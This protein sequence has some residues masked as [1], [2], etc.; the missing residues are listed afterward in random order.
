MRRQGFETVIA[1]KPCLL[2]TVFGGG[3]FAPTL[4]RMR[5]RGGSQRRVP[6]KRTGCG[7][8]SALVTEAG[9]DPSPVSIVGFS[10]GASMAL[11]LALSHPDLS[12]GYIAFAGGLP[13]E[14]R[15]E[16]WRTVDGAPV[17]L[18]YGTRDTRF[19]AEELDATIDTLSDAREQI[20][21]GWDA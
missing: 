14:V 7:A 15:A 3:N 6:G 1:P 18:G 11:D 19:N 8:T 2:Q 4:D 5:N 10:Q 12:A 13:P 9:A 16:G 21:S 20:F 17:L